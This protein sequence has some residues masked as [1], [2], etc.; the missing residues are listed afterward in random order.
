[1]VLVV[2]DRAVQRRPK[3]ERW[4]KELVQ[5]LL[6]TPWCNPVLPE[7]HRAPE[8]LP[9]REEP[10]SRP[11]PEG[12]DPRE[13]PEHVYIRDVDLERY[14][15]TVCC[16]RCGLMREGR[17]ARGIRH[18]PACLARVE[19]A[20]RVAGDER[21]QQARQRQDEELARRIEAADGR[22]NV[23]RERSEV[24][25]HNREVGDGVLHQP[26][27][28]VEEPGA[29]LEEELLP[30]DEVG[31]GGGMQVEDEVVGDMMESV[32]M[33]PGLFALRDRF[34]RSLPLLM[35]REAT[36]LYDFLLTTGVS[37]GDAQAK[38]AELY[39]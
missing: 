9:P 39:I 12:P 18:A 21:L 36:R 26:P 10:L 30:R 35:Y 27:Q 16:R 31:E 29:S 28:L 11:A 32:L 3:E 24:A 7:D 14:G 6:A 22:L 5:N 2:E 8:V 25:G 23:P 15:Y 13:G 17:P 1:L 34:Q 4:N 37:P 20:M 19:E 38:A 33:A